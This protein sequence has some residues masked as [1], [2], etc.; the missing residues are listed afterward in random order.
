MSLISRYKSWSKSSREKFRWIAYRLFRPLADKIADD[1]EYQEA[2]RSADIRISS[3][4]YVS[5]VLLTSTFVMILIMILANLLMIPQSWISTIV[6]VMS[7]VVSVTN[8]TIVIGAVSESFIST[9]QTVISTGTE[10]DLASVLETIGREVRVIGA[11]LLAIVS[12][13]EITIEPIIFAFDQ[14]SSEISQSVNSGSSSSG[15][16]GIFSNIEYDLPSRSTLRYI[17]MFFLAPLFAVLY[18]CYKMFAPYYIA[19]ERARKID[20]NLGRSYTFLSALSAGGLG[21][22]ESMSKLAESE[23]AYGESSRAFQNIIRNASKAE[24]SISASIEEVSDRTPS[25]KFREFL[26]GLKNT[27][28]TGSDVH[29]YI[30]SRAERAIEDAREKQESTLELYELISEIYIIIFLASPVFLIILQLVQAISGSVNRALVQVIPY[31][32]IPIGGF[33]IAGVVY[34]TG[35]NRSLIYQ[36][37]ERNKSSIWYDI[38]VNTNLENKYG[39][40]IRRISY[41]LRSIKAV[42]LSPLKKV[43]YNPKLTLLFTVPTGLILILLFIQIGLIPTSGISETQVE[44]NPEFDTEMSLTDRINNQYILFT[45]LGMYVPFIIISLPWSVMYELKRRKREKVVSQL[46]QMFKSISEANKRGLSLQE[47]LE[48]TAMS[49]DSELYTQMK[50]VIRR[51]KV[52]NDINGSLILLA[53]RM[54]VPRLSQSIRLL[55]EANNVSSNVTVVV[56]SISEDLEAKYSLLRDRKQRGRMYVAIVFISF[57]ILTGVLISIDIVFFEFLSGEISSSSGGNESSM[58]NQEL[59]Q[60]QQQQGYGANI[61]VQFLRRSFLHTVFILGLVSGIVSGMMENGNPVNGLKYSII[62]TTIGIISYVGIPII[63]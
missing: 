23:D 15:G 10:A 51:S 12:I 54:R 8:V 53:N 57:I 49:S 47:S 35:T 26:N 18:I 44:Q 20:N 36:K 38:E 63:F 1:T 27:I 29:R 41:T 22:Y 50:K 40:T 48:S 61:P 5:S 6:N 2:L 31:V 58:S 52:T 11:L 14:L 43:R 24:S 3:R 4:Q 9:I 33:I 32:M 62:L 25:D 42:I 34:F 45:F 21:P 39:S 37:L 7:A 59:N 60:Q 56:E 28:D 19:G 55:V 46:P 13:F 16:G 30:E 17:I